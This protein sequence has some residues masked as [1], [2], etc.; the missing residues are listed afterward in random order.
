MA[1][2]GV[3]SLDQVR[4]KVTYTHDLI[5]TGYHEA[6]HA[7]CALLHFWRV[8]SIQIYP[9]K[10]KMRTEG[11]CFNEMVK[12][13]EKIQDIELLNA[14]LINEVCFYYAG[15]ISEKYYFKTISGSDKFPL[16]LRE[17]SFSDTMAATAIIKKHNLAEPGR[18]RYAFKK[19][20]IKRTL[21][22]LQKYWSDITLLAHALFKKKRIGAKQIKK[23]LTT[24]S[25]N[26]EFW[27]EQ[28]KK[29]NFIF[30]NC[31]TIDENEIK[32][33]ILS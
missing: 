24:K 16:F 32:S 19:K 15:L 6:G 26:K 4:K 13:Y 10:E 9:K 12:A 21:H 8:S 14:Q 1:N 5:S 33:I 3:G 27:K 29:I 28:F 2:N 22:E 20:L 23:I 25:N 7:I 30:D 11:V 18:K 31:S 17:G